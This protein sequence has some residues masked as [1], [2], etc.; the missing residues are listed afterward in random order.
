MVMAGS[1]GGTE[2]GSECCPQWCCKAITLGE[3]TTGERGVGGRRVACSPGLSV[4]H[5]IF[6]IGDE[7]LAEGRA[8]QAVTGETRHKPLWIV[9][10]LRIPFLF[11]Q[12]VQT[13]SCPS[14]KSSLIPIVTE[15]NKSGV[16]GYRNY[17]S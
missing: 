2:P 6:R 10:C 15:F 5:L 1:R 13:P 7:E 17:L 11:L 8:T 9:T 16:L 3:L 12:L 4:E 14:R